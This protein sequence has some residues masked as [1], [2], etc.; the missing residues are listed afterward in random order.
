MKDAL[1]RGVGGKRKEADP[2]LTEDE[3]VNWEN[4]IFGM[5]N[6]ETIQN[7]VVFFYCCKLLLLRGQDKH[8]SLECNQF[9]LGE[10]NRGK[11]IEFTVRS[12]KTFNGGLAHK[13]LHNKEI[14]HYCQTGDHLQ[15]RPSLRLATSRC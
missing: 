3:A 9:L 12:T 14:R 8:H 1:S 10:D 15:V 7:T 5:N 11:F 4:G 13:E 2:I 6:A